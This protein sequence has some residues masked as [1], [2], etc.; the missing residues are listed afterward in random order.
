MA[1]SSMRTRARPSRAECGVYSGLANDRK[2]RVG[3]S[4]S[5]F[6]VSQLGNSRGGVTARQILKP[7]GSNNLGVS[8]RPNLPGSGFA[9]SAPHHKPTARCR[10][11]P[12]VRSGNERQQHTAVATEPHRAPVNTGSQGVVGGAEATL[13]D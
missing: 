3:E 2:I 10:S 8:R 5:S 13:P 7:I 4:P 9:F 1:T 12:V 11:E 6:N